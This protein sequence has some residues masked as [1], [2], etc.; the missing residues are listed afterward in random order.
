MFRKFWL[1]SFVLV[2]ALG[3]PLQA[4]EGT[5]TSLLPAEQCATPQEGAMFGGSLETPQFVAANH[6]SLGCS[7]SANCWDSSTVACSGGS[8]VTCVGVDSSCSAQQGYVQCGSSRTN[9]PPC[10]ASSCP[11]DSY[12]CSSNG[13]CAYKCQAVCEIPFG[14]CINNVCHCGED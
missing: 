9:C 6:Q 13:F 5:A 12:E 3:L 8:G 11:V 10:P 4:V 2:F 14:V 7:A 1:L